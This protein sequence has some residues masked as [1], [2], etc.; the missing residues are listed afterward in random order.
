GGIG[1]YVQRLAE[2]SRDLVELT[3]VCFEGAV[4]ME[5]VRLVRLP[6]PRG[7]IG[8]Y[9]GGAL[10]ASRA[11]RRLRPDLVH[12]HGDDVLLARGVPL[13]RTFYGSSLGEAR[14]SSG[15]RKL[16]HYV[17]AGFEARSAARATR[18]LAIAPE[19]LE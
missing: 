12:S 11:I 13:V 10:R 7:R 17:L 14:S 19:S 16:N 5:G 1:R 3:V 8:R 9:Y 4:P 6:A 15:L 18:T 2:R